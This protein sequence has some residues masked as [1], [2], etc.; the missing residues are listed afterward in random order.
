MKAIEIL[1]AEHRV[2]ER[3]LT[4]L[5]TGTWM[6]SV[7]EPLHLEFFNQV[8]EFITGF[9]DTCHHQKEEIGRASCRERV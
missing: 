8:L 3:V 1:C 6:L 2:I 5:E 9:A 4:A 7:E